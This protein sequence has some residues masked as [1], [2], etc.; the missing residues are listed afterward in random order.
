NIL[1]IGRDHFM[2]FASDSLRT[3]AKL[4]SVSNE[5]TDDAFVIVAAVIS[6]KHCYIVSND[7]LNTHCHKLYRPELDY[8]LLWRRMRQIFSEQA[9]PNAPR[10]RT[11]Q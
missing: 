6:G 3:V 4:F 11:L 5:T 7:Q 10:H 9:E 1:V 8:F 2:R